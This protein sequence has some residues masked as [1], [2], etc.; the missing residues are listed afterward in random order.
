[1]SQ[2]TFEGG[3]VFESITPAYLDQPRSDEVSCEPSYG[4][5][6]PSEKDMGLPVVTY[7]Q[8]IETPKVATKLPNRK[9]RR[10][11]ARKK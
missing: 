4:G 11:E 1:M 9:Q 2:N 5:L 8:L 10:Q 6:Y 3:K 7:A